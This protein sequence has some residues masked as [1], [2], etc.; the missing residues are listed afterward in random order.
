MYVM[1]IYTVFFAA[2]FLKFSIQKFLPNKFL[3]FFRGICSGKMVVLN[4]FKSC[5]SPSDTI[6]IQEQ[7]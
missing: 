2:S 5:L 6:T 4:K 7:G 3:Y 1:Y